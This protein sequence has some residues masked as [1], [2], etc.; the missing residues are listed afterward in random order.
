MHLF[1]LQLNIILKI[2]HILLKF[3]Q[4]NNG[5]C[6]F[7][8][9]MQQNSWSTPDN[10]ISLQPQTCPNFCLQTMISEQNFVSAIN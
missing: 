4:Y 6:N 5:S 7:K 9:W 3:K 10:L 8:N 1:I 2:L